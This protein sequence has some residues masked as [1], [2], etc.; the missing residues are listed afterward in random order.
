MAKEW[1]APKTATVK[2][3]VAMTEGGTIAQSGDTAA[4]SKSF[5]MQGIATGTNFSNTKMVY[6]AFVEGLAGG[7]YDENSG[8]KIVEY[9]VVE[10]A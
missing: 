10:E 3:N 8:K 2:F 9:K 7:R 6:S 1:S 5:P 4:G